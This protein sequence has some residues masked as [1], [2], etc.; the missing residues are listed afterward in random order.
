MSE[1]VVERVE[2]IAMNE[3]ATEMKRGYRIF[4]WKHRI[5]DSELNVTDYVDGNMDIEELQVQ[6]VPDNN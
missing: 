2:E 1:D 6:D 4:T 3:D 5:I